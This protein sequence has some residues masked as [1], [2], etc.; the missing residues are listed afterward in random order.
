MNPM[1]L[2]IKLSMFSL[3][4]TYRQITILYTFKINRY[5]NKSKLDC[6][7]SNISD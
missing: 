5:P 2:Q 7:Y 4:R 3:C 1:Y 6:N